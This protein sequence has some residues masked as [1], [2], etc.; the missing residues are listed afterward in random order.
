[1]R[2]SRWGRPDRQWR[3]RAFDRILGIVRTVFGLFALRT[4]NGDCIYLD[5]GDS[6]DAWF[7][8]EASSP[9]Q[10]NITLCPSDY[11]T[12]VVVYRGACGSLVRVACDDDSC[13]LNGP[14]YTSKILNLPIDAATYYIRVGGWEGDSGTATFG[15][16]FEE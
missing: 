3:P 12:S 1:M 16:E 10:L 5:W 6:P 13:Q 15:V 14:L 7:V 11:D 8:Y 4:E 9:G 2:R